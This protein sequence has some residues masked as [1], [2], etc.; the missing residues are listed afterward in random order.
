MDKHTYSNSTIFTSTDSKSGIG[1]NLWFRFRNIMKG[2]FTWESW[3]LT[4]MQ[5]I[6]FQF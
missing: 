1:I 5:N 2:S 4:V 3:Q 6:N